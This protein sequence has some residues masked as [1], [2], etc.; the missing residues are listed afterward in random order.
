MKGTM[1]WPPEKGTVTSETKT[2]GDYVASSDNE[3]TP[4]EISE[5]SAEVIVRGIECMKKLGHKVQV[6][7]CRIIYEMEE[8]DEPPAVTPLSI[9]WRCKVQEE[10]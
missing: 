6:V 7:S 1:G 9:G 8:M 10:K 3:M 4:D 5:K 2:Y